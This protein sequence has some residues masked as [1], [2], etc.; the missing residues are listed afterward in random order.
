MK[1]LDLK[2]LIIETIK[3]RTSTDNKRVQ[4]K[5]VIKEFVYKVVNFDHTP[6]INKFRTKLEEV[7][8]KETNVAPNASNSRIAFEGKAFN[9]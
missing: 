4:L 7:I 9:V 5:K 1:K 2:Q 6:S 8:G 3:N